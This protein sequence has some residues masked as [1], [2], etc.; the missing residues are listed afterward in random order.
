M[1]PSKEL[2]SVGKHSMVYVIGQVLS[3]GVGFFMIPIYT[4]FIVPRDYGAM[5]LIEIIASGA[6]LL[7]SMNVSDAMPRYYYAETEKEARNL[8]VST[9]LLG[10]GAV[11]IAIVC[12]FVGFSKYLSILISDTPQFQFNLQ[13]AIVTVLTQEVQL[14]LVIESDG[15]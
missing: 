1:I 10:F 13:I 9:T 3:R 11:G 7:I 4:R 2:V 14:V 8:V 15:K 5:E 12:L 6:G